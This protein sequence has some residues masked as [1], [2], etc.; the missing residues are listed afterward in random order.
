MTETGQVRAPEI[1]AY[2]D[3][4]PFWEGAAEGRLVLQVCRDTGRFQHPPR[5]VSAYTGSRNLGWL[6]AS[7]HGVLRAWT[8]MRVPAPGFEARVP[9]VVGV[10]DLVEGVRML[11]EVLGHAEG[12]LRV[13]M[14]LRV[15][16]T[17]VD[18]DLVFPAFSPDWTP[19]PAA[20]GAAGGV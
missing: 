4:R 11:A 2:M 10:V 8:V 5:P 16:W 13:G 17:R 1:G 6:E 7:G 14:P 19:A 3:T 9:Y 18:G 12:E 20:A 15:G